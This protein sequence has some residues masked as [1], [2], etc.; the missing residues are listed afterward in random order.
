MSGQANPRMYQELP[1]LP[2]K[3][4]VILS[5]AIT[6]RDDSPGSLPT[7]RREKTV[8]LEITCVKQITH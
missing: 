8:S 5:V 3:R 7:D 4:H 2:M 6:S 1:G